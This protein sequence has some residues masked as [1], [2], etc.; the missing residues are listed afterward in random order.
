MTP[1]HQQTIENTLQLAYARTFELSN[2][3]AIPQGKKPI[4]YTRDMLWSCPLARDLQAIAAYIEGY[5]VQEDITI[6]L[7]RIA[8]TLFGHTLSQQGFR[9]PPKFQHT[10]LGKM[11]FA[12][13]ERYFP[14][15]AWMTTAEVQK[16][17][18]VKR[19][20]V[21]DWA[22][23]GKLTAYFVNGRQVYL[24]QQVEKLYN[25]RRKQH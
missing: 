15:N 6:T 4:Q 7:Q 13:F 20:T 22:E 2:A 23:E 5:Q 8:R 12:A 3:L 16:L 25:T 24:R 21:Y 17:F 9:L 1:D 18:Q 14:P 11:M 19:Q 10:P